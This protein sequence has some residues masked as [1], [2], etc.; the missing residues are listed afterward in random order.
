MAIHVRIHKHP[1]ADGKCRE[2]V[3]KIRRLIKEE[4]LTPNAKISTIS[5]SASK[6]FLAIHLLDDNGDGIMELLNDKKL[7]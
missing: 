2:F 4:D 1:M 6:N 7:E 3:D 5:L